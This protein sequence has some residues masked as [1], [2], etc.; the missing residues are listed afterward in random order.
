MVEPM[1]SR[2]KAPAGYLTKLL[3]L[4]VAVYSHIPA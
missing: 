4:R 2:T 3:G 1:V